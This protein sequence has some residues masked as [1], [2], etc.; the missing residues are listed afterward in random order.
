MTPEQQRGILAIALFAA[1][2]DGAKDDRERERIRQMAE[3]LGGEAGAPDLASLYQDALLKRVSPSSAVL[4]ESFQNLLGPAKEM[5]ARYLPQ[6]QQTAS[7][8]DSAQVM[9]MVRGA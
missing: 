3:S 9:A 2:A 6:I 1:F 4:R 8:L 7:G 5:Q